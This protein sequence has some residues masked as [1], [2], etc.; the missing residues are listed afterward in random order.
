M[1]SFGVA[2]DRVGQYSQGIRFPFGPTALITPFNFPIEIPGLQLI[3]GILS[4]NKVLLKGDSRVSIVLE[5]L[6]A[7]LLECG[8]DPQYV[9]L[10]HADKTNSG[11]LFKELKDVLRVVQFTGSS[12]V[13]EQL[14]SLYKGKVR[15][16][17]R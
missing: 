13:A 7:D 15:I 10:V 14:M 1:K 2:G 9:N 5:Q 8:L 17:D 11:E 4:G 16:E 3:G 12:A 6:I